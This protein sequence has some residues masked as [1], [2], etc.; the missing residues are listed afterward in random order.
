M[1]DKRLIDANELLEKLG[2]RYLATDPSDPEQLGYFNARIIVRNQP[3][4]DAVP[5]V[6][7]KDCYKRNDPCSC[8]MCYDEWF[9]DEDD[10]NDFVRHDETEDDGFCHLGEM[11]DGGTP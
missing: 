8:P 1:S 3:T 6:R 2:E 4:S 7:C 5:V 10:G 9:Y 11:I